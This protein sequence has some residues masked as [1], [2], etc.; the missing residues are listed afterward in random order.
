M[1]AGA[2]FPSL[3]AVI[4]ALPMAL[5]VTTPALVTLAIVASLVVQ[6]MV[7]PLSALPCASRGVAVSVTL[8]P[9]AMVALDWS[10]PTDAT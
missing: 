7:W 3:V 2:D 1:V 10:R 4:V 6:L 5:P 8:P 9:R